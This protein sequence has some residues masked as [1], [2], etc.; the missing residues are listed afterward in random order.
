MPASWEVPVA[1][2]GPWLCN[3][4]GPGILVLSSASQVLPLPLCITVTP[5]T[6]ASVH[7]FPSYSVSL[8]PH[9]TVLYT[10]VHVVLSLENL[11]K[12]WEL[13]HRSQ[14]GKK[15]EGVWRW[16]R[17]HILQDSWTRA[18]VWIWNWEKY[19]GSEVL[20]GQWWPVAVLHDVLCGWW[21]PEVIHHV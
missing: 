5:N 13:D 6:K 18:H 1:F 4:G 12:T 17:D 8:V 9:H 16:S 15:R 14:V 19:N 7:C 21:W 2:L 11:T 3:P 10:A 20:W